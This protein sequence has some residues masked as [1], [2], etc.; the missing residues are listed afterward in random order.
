M[1][2]SNPRKRLAITDLERQNIRHRYTSHPSTQPALI[3]WYAAQP[4]GRD[5]TQGQISSIL[6]EKYQYLDS[7]TRKKTQLGSKRNYN[8]EHPELEA[9]LFEW[10]QRMQNKKAIITGDILKT[11]AHELWERLPQYT[12]DMDE[13]KWS[14]GWLEGF[15]K[16]FNIKEY[17]QHGEAATADIYSPANITQIEEL[18]Q[19]CATYADED[20]FNMDETGLFWKMA[21]TRTLATEA[22]SGGKKSKDRITLAFTTNVTG[23]EKLDIWIIGKSK[24]PRCFKKVDLNRMRI[25]YRYNKSKWMTALIMKEYLCWL[26]NKMR[27]R[28]ILLLLDNFSG[29]ELGV[30]LVGGLEGLPNIRIAWLPPNTTSYWQPLDQGIIASFK[31]GYRKQWINYMLR[32]LEADKNPN[33]TVNILKAIQWSRLAWEAL[34]AYKIQKCWWKSTVIPKPGDKD[35]LQDNIAEIE[36]LRTEIARLPGDS[37]SIQDFLEPAEEIIVDEDEDIFEAVVE[38]YSITKGDDIDEVEDGGEEEIRPSLAE[39]IKALNTLQLFT[40]LGEDGGRISVIKALEQI[41]KDISQ[42]KKAKSIQCS[43]DSWLP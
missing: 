20:I 41:G 43:L 42:E 2:A 1:K 39:A 21:P 19:L 18:R 8:G 28:K 34:E 9:A 3:A 22:L 13:P 12:L 15:K 14:N 4:Q 37:I 27:Y 16:R 30:Q 40:S 6:S 29:H 10:Q 38:R 31:L 35:I 33:K 7:D 24:K 11:K 23:S 26:N 5:L 25:Q 32:Q 36:E 17:I